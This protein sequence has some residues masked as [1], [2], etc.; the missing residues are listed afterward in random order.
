MENVC[1]EVVERENLRQVKSRDK[2]RLKVS[3]LAPTFREKS[4]CDQSCREKVCREQEGSEQVFREQDG[5]EQVCRK[6]V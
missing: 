6:Q 3:A 2:F 4:S 1:K 5:S